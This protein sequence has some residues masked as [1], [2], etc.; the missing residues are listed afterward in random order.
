M[1][2]RTPERRLDRDDPNVP[3]R[4]DEIL[5]R[6]EGEGSQPLEIAGRNKVMIVS[7]REFQRLKERKPT[8][9]EWLLSGP[10]LDEL[11]LERDPWP[12]REIEL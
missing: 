11:D 9:K 8:F 7:E 5:D 12:P 2:A 10:P 4:L 3:L 1:F 6:V